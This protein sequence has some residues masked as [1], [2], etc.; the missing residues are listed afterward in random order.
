MVHHILFSVSLIIIS[1]LCYC[2]DKNP[3]RSG[4]EPS[5]PGMVL[6]PSAN[7]TALLGSN[8]PDAQLDE[9][10][11]GSSTFTYNFHMDTVEVTIRLFDS[12][13]GYI[14]REYDTIASFDE[15]WPVAY[16]S[17]YEAALFCN[18]RSR[19]EDLDTVYSYITAEKTG[20]GDITRLAGLRCE[21]GNNGYRLPTEAEWV[22]AARAEGEYEYLWGNE[23]LQ[24]SAITHAWYNANSGFHPHAVATLSSN[25]YGLYDLSGNLTEW[26]NENKTRL[27]GGKATDYAGEDNGMTTLKIL[28]GGSYSQDLRR[29][30]IPCRSDMYYV[31]AA[32]K[33]RYTGFRC[34][35]GPIKKPS[36]IIN[37]N[38][39]TI[40]E[41]VTVVPRSAV[42]VFGTYNAKLVFVN[43][44]GRSTRTLCYIDY[45]SGQQPLFHQFIDRSDVCNPAVSPDGK[46]VAWSTGDEGSSGNSTVSV[47]SLEHEDSVPLM[48]PD[49]PAFVPRW[50]IDPATS[51]TFLLYVTST[52]MN[53]L[54]A[55]N[56]AQTKM[57][58]VCNG[59]FSG[60]PIIVESRG[61]YHGGRSADGVYLATG[62][63]L[64]K[65]INCQTRE[66]RTLF[67]AP[68]NGK[69]EGDTSQV[70]NVSISPSPAT[71][72]Q[73]LFLDFGS[74]RDTSTLTGCVYYAHEY[75]F[76]GDFSGN[77]L[78]WYHVPQPFYSWDH[79]EWSTERSHAVATVTTA[80]GS[81]RSIMC[82]NLDNSAVTSLCEGA[83]LYHPCL[84]ISP[85]IDTFSTTLDLD[86]IGQ[87]DNP[88]LS[89]SQALLAYK[90]RLFWQVAPSL[91]VIFV[92]SSTAADGIDP[93]YFTHC[94]GF[95]MAVGAGDPAMSIDLIRN[96][97]L[98]HC[99]RIK[100]IG[101]GF[102][103]NYF[104]IDGASIEL[105]PTFTKS[106]G[107]QYDRS[108]NFWKDSIPARFLDCINAVPVPKCGPEP[109]SIDSL[110]LIRF[111]CEGWG[112][113]PP[114]INADITSM[115]FNDVYRRNLDMLLTTV[116]TCSDRNIKVLLMTF[117]L[118]PGYLKTE[119][120]GPMGPS[121]IA[122]RKML[123]EVRVFAEENTNLIVY[124]ANDP[125][126]NNY[127]SSDFVDCAHLCVTGA[128][129]LSTRVDSILQLMLNGP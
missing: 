107:Y 9:K 129:K 98:N 6:I 32:S 68:L 66:E 123:E 84:W 54:V 11:V 33:N 114:P 27:N 46:W 128:A 21:L 112:P 43:R 18:A 104:F 100:I 1:Y 50:F 29:L 103:M 56:A 14:P 88:H 12:V 34:V 92:G 73:V 59:D 37:N 25:R 62:Y 82:I 60:T 52:Q 108:N 91:D 36:F 113:E 67:Y 48:L 39:S 61:A 97:I 106:N 127:I 16:I 70:C 96:Y 55:W 81:H 19:L 49:T 111:A 44:S 40:I 53:D 120:Y 47:R 5:Y 79:T 90:M 75:L 80:D 42:G 20:E 124:D 63:P 23:P 95:N 87:Y 69:K 51:D 119:A 8:N 85:G 83:D 57:I 22:F 115:L 28:K 110:G 58:R 72:D 17:W 35:A 26:I 4:H 125:A 31:D 121:Q 77:V 116:K 30:R 45:S 94:S 76:L 117:P 38:D 78:H 101:I 7:R 41:P 122:A 105:Y 13:M 89:N 2:T 99:P 74:G 102:D 65:M 64:L 118:H 10:P 3:V 86:S 71:S 109:E 93:N 15:Q 126:L 24:D